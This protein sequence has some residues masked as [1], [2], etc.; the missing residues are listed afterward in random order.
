[1]LRGKVSE[2]GGHIQEHYTMMVTVMTRDAE[3][4][5]T[6]YILEQIRLDKEQ[7]EPD[8]ERCSKI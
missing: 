3:Y 1:M 6:D 5:A 4:D 2:S 8:N 7:L